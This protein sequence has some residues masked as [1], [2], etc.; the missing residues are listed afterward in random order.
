M[1]GVG[2][3]GACSPPIEMNSSYRNPLSAPTPHAPC[4]SSVQQQC[5]NCFDWHHDLLCSNTVL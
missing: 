3:G 2:L 5:K 1:E 4:E